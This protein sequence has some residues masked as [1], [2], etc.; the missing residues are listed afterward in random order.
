MRSHTVAFP[1]FLQ[2]ITSEILQYFKKFYVL[3]LFL[4]HR[5]SGTLFGPVFWRMT[6]NFAKRY[7]AK[8]KISAVGQDAILHALPT[9]RPERFLRLPEI[10]KFPF[11]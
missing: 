7:M 1:L 11:P 5:E 4:F 3:N 6:H 9:A 8:K 10:S 2:H